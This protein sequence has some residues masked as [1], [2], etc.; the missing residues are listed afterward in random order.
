MKRIFIQILF[1]S[2]IALP[3]C[4][5]ELP[6]H[7]D[8]LS[9]ID[10]NVVSVLDE[11]GHVVRYDEEGIGPKYLPN[12][13]LAQG[14][15]G[16][17]SYF[18]P[19]VM[20]EALYILDYPENC[21]KEAII[22]EI[23]EICHKV[24]TITGVKYFSRRKKG[25]A[26]L[27]DDVYA[28]DDVKNHKKIADPFVAEDETETSIFL[29]M[30]ENALGSDYYRMDLQKL[31]KSLSIELT[32]ETA[33]RFIFPVV[34]KNN[35]IIK[36]ALFPCRD[37]ILIYGYCG[38]ILENDDLVKRLMDPYYSF[39]RRMTAMETWLYNN[40]N[41]SDSLPPLSDPLP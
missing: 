31:D 21:D 18:S 30:D 10:E 39:Y 35:M 2:I 27:F 26:V 19:E 20:V 6:S 29:H 14:I 34:E 8:L 40:L 3:L 37:C 36:L 23:Y 41:D 11:N 22:D 28:I 33:L 25:Y 9:D 24:S 4:A 12:T 7:K 32:N 1:I 16:F 38:V 13:A 5:E 15:T 17:H